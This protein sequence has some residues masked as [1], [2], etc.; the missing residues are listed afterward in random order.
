[1]QTD[2]LECTLGVQGDDTN[3]LVLTSNGLPT[4]HQKA[5]GNNYVY[6]HQ[7]RRPLSTFGDLP[8]TQSQNSAAHGFSVLI[9]IQLS[10][11]VQ[12]EVH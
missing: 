6:T 9:L 10:I 7:I 1:L 2:R 12:L 3:S 4:V 5:R 8:N 11:Q